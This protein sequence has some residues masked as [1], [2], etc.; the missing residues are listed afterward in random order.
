[1][2]EHE[3]A[4]L[5]SAYV[6]GELAGEELARA[7]SHLE[8]CQAC[9]LDMESLRYAKRMLSRAPRR[10]MPPELI[11]GIE[12]RLEPAPAAPRRR[13]WPLSPRAWFPAGA[14]ATAALTGVVWIGLKSGASDQEIPLEA[15]L[16][17]HCRYA[18]EALV[19][20]EN[21]A[22]AHYSSPLASDNGETNE[23][24]MD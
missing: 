12:Q 17:A 16:A 11:A 21:L 4:E 22:A 14:L 13:V 20:E 6:D 15:L 23:P 10:A 3:E 19:P 24:E 2:K 9:R 5:L 1:M 18:A 7:Q 8:S